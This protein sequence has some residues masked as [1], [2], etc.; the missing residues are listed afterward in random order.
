MDT[1]CELWFKRSTI[2]EGEG[3]MCIDRYGCVNSIYLFRLYQI[4]L[5]N[6]NI[7]EASMVVIVISSIHVVLNDMH[8]TEYE[9][10]TSM[11]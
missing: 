8:S 5:I 4:L 1:R 7:Y 3:C 6:E 11:A 2:G 9:L 10:A